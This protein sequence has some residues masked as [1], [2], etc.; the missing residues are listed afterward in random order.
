M[1]R[2]FYRPLLVV[3]AALTPVHPLQASNVVKA[4]TQRC[5]VDLDA[6]GIFAVKLAKTHELKGT[7]EALHPI[8]PDS[9]AAHYPKIYE[10]ILRL[11]NDRPS[12]LSGI[13]RGLPPRPGMELGQI[14]RNIRTF[15]H[16]IGEDL[17]HILKDLPPDYYARPLLLDFVTRFGGPET[18]LQQRLEP[19]D[20]TDTHEISEITSYGKGVVCSLWAELRMSLRIGHLSRVGIKVE[21]MIEQGIVSNKDGYL[22]RYLKR[23]IDH[24]WYPRKPGEKQPYAVAIGETKVFDAPFNS[25][26]SRR[27]EVYEQFETHLEIASVVGAQL[28]LPPQLYYF[29]V[30]GVTQAQIDRMEKI[31]N[32]F[33]DR[34]RAANTTNRVPV[35]LFVFGDYEKK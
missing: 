6:Q 7:F 20:P 30:A 13:N 21:K 19:Y 3:L 1:A 8:D 14:Y 25:R 10:R 11:F 12:Y 22:D 4:A 5:L 34:I 9:V 15:G 35:E 17:T 33:N 23:E 28:G 16:H 31:A 18:A 2:L 26:F 29:F 27:D 24:F 32:E